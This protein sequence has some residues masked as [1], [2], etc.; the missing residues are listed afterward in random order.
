LESGYTHHFKKQH[1][2]PRTFAAIPLAGRSALSRM[3]LVAASGLQALIL[4]FIVAIRMRYFPI[5]NT[6]T[7]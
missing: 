4:A 3:K 7:S 6:T 2:L 1:F 5:S